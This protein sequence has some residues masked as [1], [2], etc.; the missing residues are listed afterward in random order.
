MLVSVIICTHNPR[1]D[2][3][4]RVL[5]ALKAQT[6]PVSEWELLLIDNDSKDP[7]SPRFDISWHPNGRHIIEQTLGLTP[8]RL[9]GIGEAIAELLVFVDDDNVLDPDYLEQATQIAESHPFLGAWGGT[10]RPEFEAEPPVWT[11]PYWE[12]LTIGEVAADCWSNSI[13]SHETCPSGAGMCIRLTVAKQYSFKCRNDPMR[14]GLDRRGADLASGGDLDMA[15]TA[16]DMGLG[17][18]MFKRLELTHLIPSGRL[19][20]EYLLRMVEAQSLS[21]VFLNSLRGIYPATSRRK[22]MMQRIITFVCNMC[23]DSR[24]RRFNAAIHKA[25]LEAFRMLA[26]A[27]RVP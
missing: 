17:T 9:R 23:M 18:G 24:D 11:K 4:T 13:T 1:S 2:Y 10:R 12:R 8:A 6:L 21:G 27:G 19:D 14:T 15:W 16:C 3:L 20:E 22:T 7:V 5:A 25:K 26:E